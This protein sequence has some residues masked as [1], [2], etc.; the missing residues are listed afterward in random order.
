MTDVAAFI[1]A[2]ASIRNFCLAYFLVAPFFIN[3]GVRLPLGPIFLA[4]YLFSLPIVLLTVAQALC[5]FRHVVR[6]GKLTA[7]VL[8]LALVCM[9][10]VL[11]NT[12]ENLLR[13]EK[14]FFWYLKALIPALCFLVMVRVW[15]REDISRLYS[16]LF[17][18]VSFSLVLTVTQIAFDIPPALEHGRLSSFFRDSNHFAVLL[19]VLLA[20]TLPIGIQRMLEGRSGIGYPILNLIL[21]AAVGSTSSRSGFLITALLAGVSILATRRWKVTLTLGTLA[22]PFIGLMAAVLSSRY[23]S[24]QA[25]MS[26][27]G[28][29]WTY[30]TGL[31]IIRENPFLGVGFGNI[32]DSYR[33]YGQVYALLMGQPMDI[34]NAFLGI[35]AESGVF[36]FILYALL[37]GVPFVRLARRVA[38]DSRDFYPLADLVGLNICIIYIVHA[39]VYPEYLG[40]DEFWAYYSV[41][42]LILRERIRDPG[43]RIRLFG[44]G[45]AGEAGRVLEAPGSVNPSGNP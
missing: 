13:F 18:L 1:L 4:G 2:T 35:F 6:F 27:M 24:G 16:L 9:V 25:V 7:L 44:A 23:T 32:L 42:I 14:H 22:L 28:R 36:A 43:F 19:N 31:N 29:I 30:L 41:V 40:L 15:K 33:E 11:A 39:M 10:S 12:P 3:Q 34:H 17:C 45:P 5:S 37:I 38:S 26:D 21:L 20:F 8:A